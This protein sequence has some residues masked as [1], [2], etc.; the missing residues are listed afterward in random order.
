MTTSTVLPAQGAVLTSKATIIKSVLINFTTKFIPLVIGFTCIPFIIQH[1]GNER[2][3]ILTLIWAIIGYSTVMDLG[4][5]R[6]LT[7]HVA[8]KIGAND[9]EPLPT[10]IFTAVTTVFTI[11][12]IFSMVLWFFSPAIVDML[13]VSAGI[14]AETVVT[15]RIMVASIPFLIGNIMAM[16]VYEAYQKFAF[17]NKMNWP[18]VISNFIAPFFIL[19]FYNNLPALVIAVLAS[20]ILVFICLLTCFSTVITDFYAKASY[21]INNIKPLF[22]YSKWV[23][24]NSLFESA[25][26]L[27]DRFFVSILLNASVVAFLTT[28]SFAMNRFSGF[29][30]SAVNVVF[31]AFSTEFVQNPERCR[32]IYKKILM[33]M[34]GLMLI[35]FTII[36]LFSKPLLTIWLGDAFARQSYL[37]LSLF[38]VMFYIKGIGV[39]VQSFVDASGNM[40]TTSIINIATLPLLLACLY[41]LIKQYGV[42]GAPIALMVRELLC[43]LLKLF[44]AEKYFAEK[45]KPAIL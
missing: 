22:G 30:T 23:A 10:T 39:F 13:N 43:L 33:V 26:S 20:R 19:P 29:I 9:T 32:R 44:Y 3:G 34:G 6:A 18:I 14:K 28:P 24:L 11:G 35:P 15:I 37:C 41:V 8:A 1:L 21:R 31:P 42:V 7:Q 2:F 40:K 16:G 45:L 27:V 38:A 4:L 36:G 17:L 5:G 25:G 12:S